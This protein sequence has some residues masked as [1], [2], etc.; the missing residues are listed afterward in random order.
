MM[1]TVLVTGGAGFIAATRSPH[2][3]SY[4]SHLTNYQEATPISCAGVHSQLMASLTVVIGFVLPEVPKLPSKACQL[5]RRSYSR[6]ATL[7][8]LFV[9]LVLGPVFAWHYRADLLSQAIDLWSV[10]DPVGPADA[11]AVLGGEWRR[12]P[13]LQPI[14][15]DK[16]WSP[17]VLNED[18]APIAGSKLAPR[19]RSTP[20]D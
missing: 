8:L 12:G 15:I 7:L 14:I 10:S 3:A 2:T 9:S 20:V 16:S 6:S 18:D 17:G 4:Q 13:S 1:A 5:P 19:K 11:V